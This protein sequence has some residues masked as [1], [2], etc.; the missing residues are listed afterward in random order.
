MSSSIVILICSVLLVSCS[1]LQQSSGD[2]YPENFK[3]GQVIRDQ[4]ALSALNRTDL[5]EM[6]LTLPIIESRDHLDWYYENSSSGLL[7]DRWELPADGAQDPAVLIRL[8]QHKDGSQQVELQ[9]DPIPIEE[10][11]TYHSI[12][13]RI[14]GGWKVLKVWQK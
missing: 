9:Y 8:P 12:L 11:P 7:V 5:R 13:K 2:I 14:D 4:R 1:T 6:A 10:T 3:R